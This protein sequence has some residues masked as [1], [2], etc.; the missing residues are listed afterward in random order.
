MKDVC[1]GSGCSG[2][3]RDGI[4]NEDRG[5]RED[6]ESGSAFCEA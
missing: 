4:V 2:R 5:R 6:D 3:A 1:F